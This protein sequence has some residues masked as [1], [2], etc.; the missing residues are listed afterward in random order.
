MAC[1]VTGWSCSTLVPP[2]TVPASILRPSLHRRA[3]ISCF[4]SVTTTFDRPS[5]AFLFFAIRG[6][7]PVGDRTWNEIPRERLNI[8]ELNSIC[9][10]ISRVHDTNLEHDREADRDWRS[11]ADAEPLSSIIHRSHRNFATIEPQ[12][13]ST[14]T[15][16]SRLSQLQLRLAT[17]PGSIRR[18][19]LAI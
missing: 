15:F 13:P 3:N 9:G 16:S 11:T 7:H 18:K 8:G 10:E 6:A 17:L 19:Q 4:T 12:I 1:K 14:Q 2:R 5:R